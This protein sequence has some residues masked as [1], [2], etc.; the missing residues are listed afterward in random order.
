MLGGDRE[1]GCPF[2]I[3]VIDTITKMILILV[4]CIPQ[5]RRIP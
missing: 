5:H 3:L 2:G 4:R 1:T